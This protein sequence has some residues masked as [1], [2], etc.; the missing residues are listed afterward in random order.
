MGH[1]PPR[2]GDTAMNVTYDSA[3]RQWESVLCPACRRTFWKPTRWV[4][5]DSSPHAALCLDCEVL[6]ALFTRS[7][8][9]S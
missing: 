7:A 1:L 5:S 9:T 6:L 2:M 3:G 4:V 8:A